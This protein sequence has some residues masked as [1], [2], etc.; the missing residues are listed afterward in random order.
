MES[1]RLT[2]HSIQKFMAMETEQGVDNFL[3]DEES[4]TQSPE[5]TGNNRIIDKRR[6][7]RIQPKEEAQATL[8]ENDVIEP[9]DDVKGNDPAFDM[10]EVDE[11][12]SDDGASSSTS[13]SQLK[14]ARKKTEE[15]QS[16]SAQSLQRQLK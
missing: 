1:I 13:V 9:N 12:N 15:K 7:T 6:S 10:E 2:F 16:K 3:L 14:T 11:Q 4:G 8:E 5:N